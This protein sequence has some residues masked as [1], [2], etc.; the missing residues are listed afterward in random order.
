MKRL[1][2][3]IGEAEENCPAFYRANTP[4]VLTQYLERGRFS[5]CKFVYFSMVHD[6]FRRIPMVSRLILMASKL[7]TDNRFFRFLK[8]GVIAIATK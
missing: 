8:M 2:L 3:N 1:F 7:V 5:H 4:R 6:Y